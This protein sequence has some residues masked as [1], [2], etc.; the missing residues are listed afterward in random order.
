MQTKT[1]TDLFRYWQSAK[2]EHVAPLRNRI[3]PDKI[4]HILGDLFILEADERGDIRFRLAGTRLCAL[5]ARELRGV[6]FDSLWPYE[7]MDQIAA[8]ARGMMATP[9]PVLIRAMGLGAQHRRLGL[10]GLLLPMRAKG[11]RVDRILG[12]LAPLERA[13]WIGA[14]PLHFLSVERIRHLAPDHAGP[15]P[16][17]N[18]PRLRENPLSQAVRRVLHLAVL[19]GGRSD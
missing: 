15:S 1:A 2:G 18:P 10:E 13:A 9:R 11:E 16:T 19:E 4:R 3:E 12:A 5:F 17:P 6:T 7:E 8:E 14:E